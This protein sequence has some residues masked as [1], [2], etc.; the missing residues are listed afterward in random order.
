MTTKIKVQHINHSLTGEMFLNYFLFD[1]VS[2][3]YLK[4]QENLPIG[5]SLSD[6]IYKIARFDTEKGQNQEAKKSLHKLFEVK[7]KKFASILSESERENFYDFYIKNDM[8][9]LTFI[10][11]DS[12]EKDKFISKKIL[13]KEMIF[14]IKKNFASAFMEI[15]FNTLTIPKNNY[16]KMVKHYSY[17]V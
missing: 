11:K 13:S 4:N 17:T 8:N 3:D 6:V 1:E 9:L 7:A 5:K 12:N 10:L 2:I 15:H 16:K 14:F